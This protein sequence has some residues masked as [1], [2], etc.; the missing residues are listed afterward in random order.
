MAA[1]TIAL[2][3]HPGIAFAL[4]LETLIGYGSP[5]KANTHGVHG[6]PLGGEETGLTREALGWKYGE[7][8]IPKEVYDVYGDAQQR[9]ADAQKK[10]E[11]NL[12]QYCQKYPEEGAEFKQL[13]SG[14]QT[15]PVLASAFKQLVCFSGT[16]LPGNWS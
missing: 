14:K 4:Q 12:E 13:I 10:W 1:G 15:W 9:G 16:Q 3:A 8:E 2:L 6:S 7:F 11:Q 5:N